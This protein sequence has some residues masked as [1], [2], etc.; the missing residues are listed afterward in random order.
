[1]LDKNGKLIAGNKTFDAAQE[2]GLNVRIVQAGRNELIA[3]QRDDLDLDDSTGEARRLAYMDNRVS[4]LD[5]AWDAEQIASDAASGLDFDG[6]GFL[7]GELRLMLEQAG[8]EEEADNDPGDQSEKAEELVRKW[9]V[10]PG[11]LWQLGDHLIICADA[12]DL[13]Q[14]DML[15]QNEKA[16]LCFTSPP[17]W[18]GK[19][20]EAQT[21]E[22]EI[23]AFIEK[24]A[25]TINAVTR[26][27]ESR[28]VINT[29]TGFTTAFDK[30]SKRHVLLLV[31]KWTNAMRSL[32]WNLRHVRHWIKE[33]QLMSTSPRTDVIDQHNE[34][35]AT[36]EHEAGSPMLFSDSFDDQD[37]NLLMTFYHTQGKQRGQEWTGAAWA[38]R[39]HWDDIRGTANANGHVAAF[40]IEL[41]LRHLMLY[42]KRN[43]IV[44]EP[45]CGSGTTL[46][47]CEVM[48]RRCRAIEIEPKY[49]AA[50]LE[51]WFIFTGREP[52]RYGQ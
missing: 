37:V 35:I 9:D 5:L 2:A 27:D 21:S 38:L 41:P 11:Q 12:T 16:S 7:E 52:V 4:E 22:A 39:S 30:K 10:R 44:F 46:I 48:G 51:R 14:V 47:G 17:Y 29:G 18:V 43:E 34:F 45:F 28:I 40:P 23:D 6:A 49:M 15:M 32:G 19:E 25:M 33:G 42:T 26:R 50:T 31:D 24:M 8:A 36:Y 13:S 3:V 1:M 20:Y